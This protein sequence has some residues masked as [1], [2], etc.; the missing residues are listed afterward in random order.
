MKS[1]DISVVTAYSVLEAAAVP[2][3]RYF[4]QRETHK[5]VSDIP[6]CWFLSRAIALVSCCVGLLQKEVVEKLSLDLFSISTFDPGILGKRRSNS[7]RQCLFN[8][9]STHLVSWCSRHWIVGVRLA[10]SARQHR[11]YAVKM[12]YLRNWLMK[13]SSSRGVNN[14]S[15]I[16]DIRRFFMGP[17]LSQLNSAHMLTYYG[18]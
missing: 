2:D 13:L 18:F 9:T 1:F 8:L 15:A 14:S 11:K 5:Y 10:F 16:R 17:K 7:I 6:E 4:A 12:N 3:Y